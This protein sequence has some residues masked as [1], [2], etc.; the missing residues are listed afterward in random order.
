MPIE[1]PY[2]PISDAHIQLRIAW[3]C[4]L[5]L[6][7]DD[8]PRL[9]RVLSPQLR[10]KLGDMWDLSHPTKRLSYPVPL[11]CPLRVYLSVA[12]QLTPPDIS[13]GTHISVGLHLGKL[14]GATPCYS[15]LKS[16]GTRSGVVPGAPVG[17]LASWDVG[18]PR[19]DR[20]AVPEKRGTDVRHKI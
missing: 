16:V 8:S 17:V 2:I 9:C 19:S 6:A 11:S 14:P 15:P 12:P 4:S 13:V 1:G 18:A 7:R 10:L 5:G 3:A 20:Q